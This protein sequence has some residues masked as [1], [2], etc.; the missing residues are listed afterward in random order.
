MKALY[1]IFLNDKYMP[2]WFAYL[3]IATFVP[4]VRT[5]FVIMAL[6]GLLRL[7]FTI[8]YALWSFA[9]TTLPEYMY[10]KVLFGSFNQKFM[11]LHDKLY[12]EPK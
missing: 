3:F 10:V 6:P 1:K 11:E 8:C 7:A 2:V 5:L 9:I 12:T 4:V